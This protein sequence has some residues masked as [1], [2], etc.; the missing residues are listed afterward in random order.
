[1]SSVLISF[2]RSHDHH[3]SKSLSQTMT[4]GTHYEAGVKIQF[5]E[6]DGFNFNKIHLLQA[7]D[8]RQSP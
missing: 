6:I 4:I 8:A 7:K 3:Y 5:I 1:M 2:S